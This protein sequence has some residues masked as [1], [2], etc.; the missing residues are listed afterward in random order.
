MNY[1]TLS[2]KSISDAAN[3]T[4][5]QNID[6]D[7][8]LPDYYDTIG[9]ILKSEITTV[10]EAV[11]TSG[12]KISVAGIA[13]FSMIYYGEDKKLYCYENEYKYTKVFQSQY[14]ENCPALSVKQNVFSLNCRAIAPKRIELRAVLQ[15]GV[16]LKAEYSKVLISN[17]DN[18]SVF[19][20]KESFTFI[21]TVNCV[22]RNFS[23]SCSHSMSEFNEPIGIVLRKES[24]IKVSEIKT[25]HNKAYV[26][27]V[28]ETELFYYSNES[29]NTVS[30]V[31]TL[32][33][34]EIIDVF[35]AEEEDI[36]N[37]RFDDINTDIIIKGNDS[38]NQSLDVR[39]DVNILAEVHRSISANIVTDLFSVKKDII[40][41]KDNVDVSVACNKSTRT[42][43]I[44]FET[45]IYDDNSY[46][47]SDCWVENIR[48]NCEKNGGRY[49]LLVTA[50]FNALVKDEYGSLSVIS[51]ENTFE[52]ELLCENGITKAANVSAKVLS[53][54]ALQLS[55]GKLRFT[56]DIFFEADIYSVCKVSGFTDI[57]V[58]EL[59]STECN[60]K[61]II[62]FGKK[63]E[64]IWSVAKEN[65]TPVETIKLVNN[66]S[67]DIL[68]EDKMLLLPSF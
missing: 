60:G 21:S 10:T 43:N 16:K 26:K 41:V 2:I 36:C 37:I 54:S 29:G 52:T 22:S 38:S 53:I 14:A 4:G 39:L 59:S 23:L 65:K 50:S 6:A 62:Y 67:G 28:A 17:V 64:D 40:T 56:S 18:D 19:T 31:L 45:D 51:R 55:G 57:D 3:L 33:V 66:L 20:K 7:I 11:N 34:S 35:G 30:T 5:Q 61:Y 44:I 48:I 68:N 8:I 1:D 49:N 47:V 13:K 63:N 42:E 25:I 46:T 15:I 32:P 58:D 27:G 12:D 9:K 24:R